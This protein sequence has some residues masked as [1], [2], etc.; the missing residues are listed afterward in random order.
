MSF[1]CNYIDFF[2]ACFDFSTPMVFAIGV[3]V[4]G[5]GVV[6]RLLSGGGDDDDEL[7]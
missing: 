5:I 3:G 2:D 4:I 6:I 1:F 7:T